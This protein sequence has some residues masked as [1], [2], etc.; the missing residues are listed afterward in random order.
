MEGENPLPQLCDR[1]CTSW[2]EERADHAPRSFGLRR[3]GKDGRSITCWKSGLSPLPFP[4]IFPGV[5]SDQRRANVWDDK[6]GDSFLSG[7]GTLTR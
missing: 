5:V 7:R 2:S 3:D 1:L 6:H 4:R